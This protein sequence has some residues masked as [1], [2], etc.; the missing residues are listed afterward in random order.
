M[1]TSDF[2]RVY[3]C[4]NCRK[5]CALPDYCS[6]DVSFLYGRANHYLRTGK[7][8][9]QEIENTEQEQHRRLEKRNKLIRY[10]TVAGVVLIVGIILTVVI[11]NAF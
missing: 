3:V 8:V 6:D 9:W 10:L 1:N 2:N 7:L 11:F 5:I 4:S